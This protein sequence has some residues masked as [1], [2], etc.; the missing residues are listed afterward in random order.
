MKLLSTTALVA[1]VGFGIVTT[2]TVQGQAEDT[3]PARQDAP[4]DMDKVSREIHQAVERALEKA[5]VSNGRLQADVQRAVEEAALTAQDAVR[6]VDVRV[7][8]DDAMQ[9]MPDVAWLGR[10]RLGV[11]TRDVTAEEAKA[12]GLD[13][14]TGAYAAT[15]SPESAAGKAGLQANDIIVSVDGEAI[16]SARHLARVIAETPEGRTLQLAYVRGTTKGTVSVAPEARRLTLRGREGDGPAIRG[17]E[18][19]A[20]PG[21]REPLRRDPERGPRV[22]GRQGRLGVMAQPLT[23]QL[24]TYF[25]VKD[26][27][28]IAMVSENSAA[29]KA[30]LKAGDVITAVDGKPVANVGDIAAAL[31]GAAEGTTIRVEIARDRKTQTVSV[32]LPATANTSGDHSVP[33]PQRFT[34]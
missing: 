13:G 26:G 28:L 29:A 15:V 12:A 16:R 34:A 32:T 8:V 27:V 17:F 6:D 21:E 4:D 10:P 1:L 9:G 18:R 33:S 25:G 5:G 23:G 11:S 22:M 3:A 2:R 14:I 31:Q 20:V 19:R 7:L 24:A 30:G